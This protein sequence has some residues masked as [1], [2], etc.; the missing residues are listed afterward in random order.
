M[1]EQRRKYVTDFYKAVYPVMTE[2]AAWSNSERECL[3]DATNLIVRLRDEN[4]E[5]LRLLEVELRELECEIEHAEDEGGFYAERVAN[6][7]AAIA[8]AEGKA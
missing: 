5:L 7:K 1:G 2:L 3:T 8:K 6:I 4:A